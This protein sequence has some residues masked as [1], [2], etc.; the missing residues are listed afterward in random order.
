M[1]IQYLTY[2]KKLAFRSNF[3]KFRNIKFKKITQKWNKE[4]RN[5]FFEKK[6]SNGFHI[7][8][9]SISVSNAFCEKKI[10]I[11]VLLI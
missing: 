3:F 9:K 6:K 10:F 7:P 1:F 5:S 8:Q 2:E 11:R 4:T